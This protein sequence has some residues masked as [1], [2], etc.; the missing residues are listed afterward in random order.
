EIARSLIPRRNF[1]QPPAPMIVRQ[2]RICDPEEGVVA[3][4]SS[5]EELEQFL[6]A[7][8]NI[9]NDDEDALEENFS[10]SE[11][12]DPPDRPGSVIPFPVAQ[13]PDSRPVREFLSTL[14]AQAKAAT[15]HTVE[16]GKHP[17]LLQISLV[18]PT[19][20]K[21]SGIYRYELDDPELVESMTSD[22]LNASKSGHNVYIEGRTV[23]RGLGPKQ[24]GGL[25]DTGAV[26]ALVVDS[27]GDKGLAWSPTVPVSLAVET[28]PGNTH[29]WFFL[30]IALDPAPVQKLGARLR[31]ATNADDDTGNVCQP[32][33]VA[34]TTN[35]P[36]E[37]KRARGRVVTGTHTLS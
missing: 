19:D 16:K 10:P 21:I 26:F 4:C 25:E 35:Y 7:A 30:E 34:G 14:T 31:A 33:R 5:A 20:E 29:F 9:F 11:P 22:A 1:K 15:R 36:G 28:S 17:G 27:D 3:D 8:E 12:A 32:Y 24:R 2:L 6:A 23:R 18:H 37:K 13:K